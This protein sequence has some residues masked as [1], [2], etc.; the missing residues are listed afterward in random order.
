[1]VTKSD[2]PNNVLAY[3]AGIGSF[4]KVHWILIIAAICTS[5]FIST[6]G[7]NA[8]DGHRFNANHKNIRSSIK[9]K[10]KNFGNQRWLISSII[11]KSFNGQPG[12]FL[13]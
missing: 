1:M 3:Q 5:Q 12:F 10:G 9:L 13:C 4:K 6:F 7:F 8:S 2:S 11:S